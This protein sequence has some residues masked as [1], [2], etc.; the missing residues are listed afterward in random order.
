MKKHILVIDDEEI[1]RISIQAQLTSEGYRV[2][3]CPEVICALKELGKDPDGYDIILCDIRMPGLDGYAFLEQIK[4]KFPALTVIMMTA[5][6]TIEGAVK[7][8]RHGAYDYI[9]KPF[10]IDE[11]SI[12]LEHALEYR[13]KVQ[14][15]IMLKEALKGKHQFSNLVGKSK[16]M[17]GIFDKIQVVAPTNTTILLQG[18]TGSGKEVIASAIH[19]NSPRKDKPLIKV[20]CAM[21][22]KEVLESELFGHE[23][24]SFTGAIKMKKGRF[25]LANTGTLFLDEVDDI[26]YEL[27]V[28]LLRVI[29]QKAFERVGGETAIQS[30][31]RLIAASKYPLQELVKQGKFR[32]DLYYRL[33]VVTVNI[34]PLRERK[35]DIPL[36]VNYFVNKYRNEIRQET[37]DN[38]SDMQIPDEVLRY[39]MDYDWPGNIRELENVIKHILTVNKTGQLKVGDLPESVV[40]PRLL[41]LKSQGTVKL[42]SVVGKVEREVIEWALQKAGGNQ[43]KAAEILGIPRTTLREKMASIIH[44]HL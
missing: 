21:L 44:K 30:D 38:T 23:A 34:P 20:S 42:S 10:T 2:T 29:E 3:T 32:D 17:Q 35:E 5:Y 27:Q 33:A 15:N 1:E 39:L 16:A 24:G 36:L 9:T 28:K 25:E 7:S 37:R 26:P 19:Y 11:L 4:A 22:S 13:N 12:K 41:D 14:E 43:T 40:I 8:M 31:V 6:G 18:E